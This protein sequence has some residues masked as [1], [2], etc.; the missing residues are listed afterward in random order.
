MQWHL[1]WLGQMNEKW[2]KISL[3][4]DISIKEIRHWCNDNCL[5]KF[6]IKPHGSRIRSNVGRTVLFQDSIDAMTFKLMWS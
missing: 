2:V 5:G 4:N 1:S 3:P 6:N